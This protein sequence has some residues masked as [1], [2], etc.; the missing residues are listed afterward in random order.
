MNCFTPICPNRLRL[1]QGILLA[2][3]SL[4]GCNYVANVKQSIPNNADP[5]EKEAAVLLEPLAEYI[6]W[7]DKGHVYAI[8]LSGKQLSNKD[9]FLLSKFTHLE[10]LNLIGLQMTDDDFSQLIGFSEL[11]GLGLAWSN[12]ADEGMKQLRVLPNLRVLVLSHTGVS[13]EGLAH[14]EQ[15]KQL[16]SLFIEHT[17]VTEEG[18]KRFEEALPSCRVQHSHDFHETGKAAESSDSGSRLST[19][20]S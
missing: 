6:S 4:S 13:D 3:I 11:R 2:C 17:Q 19:L 12:I 16:N 14:L 18:I 15:L 20:D 7:N 9:W 8:D 1:A 5:Q 10:E